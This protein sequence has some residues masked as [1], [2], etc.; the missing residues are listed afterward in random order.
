MK[1]MSFTLML[2]AGTATYLYLRRRGAPAALP[3][4]SEPDELA[5]AASPGLRGSADESPNTAE[6]LQEDGTFGV[7]DRSSGDDGEWFSSSS[8]QGATPIGTGLPDLTRGA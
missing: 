7:P 8:Q 6:R 4:A 3:A 5:M 2:F 1:P